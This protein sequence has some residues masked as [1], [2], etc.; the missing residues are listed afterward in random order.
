LYDNSFRRD[1]DLNYANTGLTYG[2]YQP[3]YRFGFTLAS[4]EHTRYLPW[5]EVEAEAQREWTQ[6]HPQHPWAEF[7]AAIQRGFDEAR[8]ALAAAA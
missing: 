1:F 3:A 7:K 2:Q 8:T 4:D 5:N 6:T